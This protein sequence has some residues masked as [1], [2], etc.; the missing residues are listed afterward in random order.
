MDFNNIPLELKH[1][2]LFCV[3]KLDEKGSKIPFN[4]V[5]NTMAR[6]NNRN[7]FNS[8][9]TILSYLPQYVKVNERGELLGGLGLGIFNGFSAIDIDDCRDPKT[10][11][12]S[13]M[14]EEI[15]NYINSYTEISP[16][17]KGIRIIFKTGNSINKDYYYIN[18]RNLGLEIYIS[19][20]T[21][22]YVT[23]TGNVLENKKI[24]TA[25]ISYIL[26]K[27]MKKSNAPTIAV[28]ITKDNLYHDV[29]AEVNKALKYNKKLRELW[30]NKAPGSGSNESELDMALVGVLAH[31]F[32]GNYKAVEAAF[33]MS[34]Y[35]K[36]K[37]DNHKN[38]WL[39]RKDYKE[40]TLR[41]AITSYHAYALAKDQEFDLTD[42]GNA[43]KFADNFHGQIKYNVD[44]RQW[45]IYNGKYWQP[46]TYNHIKNLAEM[47][48]EQLKMDT[49]AASGEQ[50]E[51]MKRNVKKLLSSY[52]KESMIKE[53]QHIEGVPVK[54][55][56]FDK[57]KD[58]F[59]T[60][61]GVINL[62]T[63]EII[64]HSKE[65]ML[66]KISDIEI[67]KSKPKLFLK[68][69][70]EIFDNDTEL[71]DWFQRVAGYS[72]TGYTKE[73]SM[74]IFLGDGANG[75][76]LLLDTMIKVMGAYGTTS[77]VDILV[78]RRNGGNNTSEIARLNGMRL[79]VS[80]EAES[81]D[82]LRESAIKSM[83]SD[84]GDITARFLYGN[85]FT[86][87]PIFKL[88]MATN[89]QPII[90]GTDHGIWRRIKVI[91]FNVIIPD[92]KQDRNLAAKFDAE[93][94]SILWWMVEGAIKW[95]EEGKLTTPKAVSNSIKS[96]RSDMDVVQRWINDNCELDD[97]AATPAMDLFRDFTRWAEINKEYQLSNTMF[98][99]NLGK[100]FEKRRLSGR[101]T[102]FGIKIREVDMVDALEDIKVDSSI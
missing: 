95:F 70:N 59:N 32:E 8:Y 84:H 6:S 98:G 16:S 25:D 56:D 21:N 30:N 20:N 93:L 7:T 48:I 97:N 76:S 10:G 27:Y 92:H 17:G 19:D 83:T 23:L 1:K 68:F 37:D 47:T 65:L 5:T 55:S 101:N 86:F 14:A 29:E 90:R 28:E 60:A 54:N 58:Y 77:S 82:K 2:G 11:K 78:E 94:G 80:E 89:H 57:E 85:E 52:G 43:R 71:I 53:A 96:Y 34:P 74:F 67:N 24:N 73:Q 63:G 35:F 44:N 46:D 9:Q 64:P 13:A 22:K 66:S 79:V 41:N 99:R 31:L 36:S 50:R 51:A 69:L 45:M 40:M 100:K 62:R 61:S 88:F 18:N 75:K 39:V 102:Y 38:K 87:K 3:W 15:I 4:P 91:P 12:L 42:T 33:E 49:L 81:G 26:D 72:L